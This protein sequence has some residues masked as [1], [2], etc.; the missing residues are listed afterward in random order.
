MEPGLNKLILIVVTLVVASTVSAG[1]LEVENSLFGSSQDRIMQGNPVG[2]G[3]GG[4]SA[5][6]DTPKFTNM[7]DKLKAGF[8][9]LILP[10]AGQYYNGHYNKAYIYA[11]VEVSVWTAYG[12]FHMQATNREEDSREYAMLFADVTGTHVEDYWRAIGR[13]DNSDQYDVVL[14][15]EARATGEDAELTEPYN[16]WQWRNSEYRLGYQRLRA[17]ASRAYVNRDFTLAFAVI[18]RAVSVWDAVRSAGDDKPI[19]S[20]GGFDL[21]LTYT[22]NTRNPEAGW[23]LT[24]N[25]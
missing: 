14:L 2:G 5:E 3:I 9:S 8:F 25:F 23:L 20:I 18:N 15:R 10:G 16:Q 19:A 13:Y 6:D 1:V 11:G 22:D 17:D 21:E 7:S 4:L 12:I 24:R